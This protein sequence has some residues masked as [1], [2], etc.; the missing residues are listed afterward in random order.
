MIPKPN[1]SEVQEFYLWTVEECQA[2]LAAGEFKPNC[3]ILMLDFFVR[4]GI[5]TKENE[6]DFDEIVRRLHR[7]LEFP[8]PHSGA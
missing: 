7:E 3:S 5:I 2:R 8:G 1:D 4:H 6:P